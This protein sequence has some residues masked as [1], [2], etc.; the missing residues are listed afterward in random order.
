M[1]ATRKPSRPWRLILSTPG[2]PI[3]TQHRS[4]PEVYRA[5]AKEK[6]LIADGRSRVTRITVEQWETDYGRWAT[7]ERVSLND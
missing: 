2:A 6:A 3:Y 5:V 4:Q 1:P 7:F